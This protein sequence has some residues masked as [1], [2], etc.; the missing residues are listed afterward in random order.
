MSELDD[1]FADGH[2]ERF[3]DGK[4]VER[5]RLTPKGARAIGDETLAAAL[6]LCASGRHLPWGLC[7]I[8]NYRCACSVGKPWQ[9]S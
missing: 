6:E 8:R 7:T 2:L 4:G 5:V 9:P 1:L 3:T